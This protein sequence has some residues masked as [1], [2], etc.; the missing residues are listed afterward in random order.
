M[1]G[2]ML[3]LGDLWRAAGIEIFSD[4]INELSFIYHP[5]YIIE[6]GQSYSSWAMLAKSEMLILWLSMMIFGF[7]LYLYR[8]RGKKFRT[9][10]IY[11]LTLFV[12]IITQVGV[13]FYSSNAFQFILG[14]A[15]FPLFNKMWLNYSYYLRIIK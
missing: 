10:R 6:E 14:F 15:L 5:G 8:V 13:P 3:R 4:T 1:V 2:I 12:C 11:L 7:L 9:W